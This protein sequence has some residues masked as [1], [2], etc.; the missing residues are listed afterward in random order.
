MDSL[1][2]VPE[3]RRL[4]THIGIRQGTRFACPECGPGHCASTARR[5]PT[6]AWPKYNRLRLEER[7][8]LTAA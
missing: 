6:A 5:A 1:E 3:E 4:D 2:F 8:P 7:M